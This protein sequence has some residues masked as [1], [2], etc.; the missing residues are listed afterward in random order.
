MQREYH[1]HITHRHHKPDCH[2]SQLHLNLGASLYVPGTHVKLVE[3]ADRKKYPELRSVIFC[4]ED[5]IRLEEIPFVLSNIE[6]ALTR[7]H[8]KV[9]MLRFIRVRSPEVLSRCLQMK[10]IH[11][12][13]GFVLPKVTCSNLEAYMSQFRREDPFLVMITLETAEAFDF[14]TMVHL[15]NMLLDPIYSSRVLS[16]RIGGNDL[17]NY[18]GIRRSAEHTIYDTPLAHTISM[19]VT[20]FKPYSFNLT[21]PVCEYIDTRELL[22]RECRLDL[23]HGL[24]GKTAIHPLQIPVIENSYRVSIEDLHMAEAILSPRMPA[25]FGMYNSMCEPATHMNWAEHI[26]ARAKLYGVRAGQDDILRTCDKIS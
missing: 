5:S 7:M 25:V 21:G 24:F 17:L 23:L 15:R 4:T 22:E 18:L 12:I 26:V 3:I 19:L 16:I 11:K 14:S 8:Q 2:N 9:H 6:N 1:Q 20:I 10:G 13:D